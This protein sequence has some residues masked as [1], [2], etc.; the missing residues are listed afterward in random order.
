M[1]GEVSLTGKILPVGGIK[2]KTIAVS[3]L[4]P[5]PTGLAPLGGS[6]PEAPRCGTH[7]QCEPQARKGGRDQ[8]GRASRLAYVAGRNLPPLAQVPPTSCGWRGLLRP[9]PWPWASWGG[10]LTSC[11]DPTP[12]LPAG[13]GSQ[14][15]GQDRHL[16][17]LQRFPRPLLACN[18]WSMYGVP[19]WVLRTGGN[20]CPPRASSAPVRPTGG[21][22]SA[23]PHG[24]C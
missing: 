6:G 12:H 11:S 18:I 19:G 5:P 20:H 16:G 22:A 23:E 1:T 2:E 8:W 15:W 9:Y 10:T 7:A 3:V 17:C 14:G 24:F 13:P 4:P 21:R